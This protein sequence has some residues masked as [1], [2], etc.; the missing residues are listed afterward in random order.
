MSPIPNLPSTQLLMC[1]VSK[2]GFSTN[3]N[4]LIVCFI[5]IA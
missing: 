5:A 2:L 1:I 4:I 3:V